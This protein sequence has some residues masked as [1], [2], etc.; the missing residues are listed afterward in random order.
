MRIHFRFLALFVVT[1]ALGSPSAA[2]KTTSKEK[3]LKLATTRFGLDNSLA[4]Q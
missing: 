4:Q 3:L 1:A 2:A